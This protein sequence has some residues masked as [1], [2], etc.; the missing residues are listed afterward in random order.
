LVSVLVSADVPSSEI[1]LFDFSSL[2]G[3]PPSYIVSVASVTVG[4]NLG[5]K[6]FTAFFFF[7]EDVSIGSITNRTNKSTAT[8]TKISTTINVNM[9]NSYGL[10]YALIKTISIPLI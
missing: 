3:S 4:S 5:E 2:C 9:I 10:N 1:E 6:D 7:L 8:K